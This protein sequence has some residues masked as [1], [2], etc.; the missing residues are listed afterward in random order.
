MT[1]RNLLKRLLAGGIWSVWKGTA[2]AAQPSSIS[3]VEVLQKNWKSLLAAGIKAPL[4]SEPLKLSKDE[5]RKRLSARA[6]LCPARGGHGTAGFERAERR[7]A[8]WHLC[9]RWLRPAAVHVRDEIRK[10]H[11]LAEFFYDDTRCLRHQ[12]RFQADPAAHRIPLH[13]LRRPPRPHFQRRAATHRETLVQQRRGAEIHPE[14][15]Q[16]LVVA[17]QSLLLGGVS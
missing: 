16:S 9:L 17:N 2:L 11:R 5:W 3:E 1:R 15:R 10:R 14:N 8:A 13:A 4:A 12:H 7:E 6:V